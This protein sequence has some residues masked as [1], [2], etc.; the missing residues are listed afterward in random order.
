ML[1]NHIYMFSGYLLEIII[2]APYST[3]RSRHLHKY[4][5][6][7]ILRMI[8]ASDRTKQR[9]GCHTKSL[10]QNRCVLLKHRYVFLCRAH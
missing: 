4:I 2:C 3:K 8:T 7:A 9:H 10:T 5:Y 6:I 1:K